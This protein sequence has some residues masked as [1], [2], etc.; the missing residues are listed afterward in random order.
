MFLQNLL[1]HVNILKGH[2]TTGEHIELEIKILL[3]PR[4]KTPAFFKLDN[5]IHSAITTIQKLVRN[6]NQ[7]GTA[8]ISQT[9]NFIKT[10]KTH[11]FVKQLFFNNGIQD[12]NKK[13]YYIKKSIVPPVYL[14]SETLNQPSYKLSVNTETEHNSD[15]NKF[16]IVRFR[17]RYSISFN[18]E[19]LK[20]W[21]LELTLVKE[22][23]NQSLEQM[24]Q[25][26]DKLFATNITKDTF[27]E[28]ADWNNVDRIELE[29]E[30]INSN[31]PISIEHIS[32][33]DQLWQI[34]NVNQR[35]YTDCICQIAQ[36]IKPNILDKFKSG[37][38]GLKQLGTNP[39]ELTKKDYITNVL[40]NINNFILTEKIDG[41]RSMLIIYPQKGECHIINKQYN[42]VVCDPLKFQSSFTN[43]KVINQLI[44]GEFV[45]YNNNSECK[46]ELIILDTEEY[47]V[48]NKTLYYV[49]D[50]IWY[51][52]NVSN[53]PFA[54]GSENRLE[55]IK[56]AVNQYDFLK[57]K[58]FI[59]LNDKDYSSQIQ[60]FN[61]MLPTLP[62][63][64][65]GLIF[66][67]KDT[68]YTKTV[69]MKW[70]PINKMT[71]DFVAKV[72]PP[73]LLG[74][75]PYI[76][77]DGQT[78]YLLFVGTRSDEYHKLGIKKFKNYEKIF[79]NVQYN[80][81]YFPI[82]FSPSSDPYAYLFW[83]ENSTLDGHIV[84]LTRINNSW[85][86]Y[87]IR[88]D[89]KIDMDRKT[90]YGNYFKYAESIWMNY[91]NPLTLE[92]LSSITQKN[93]GYFQEDDNLQYT[94]VRKFNNFVKSNLNQLYNK[95]YTTNTKNEGISWVIDLASGKGQDL[96]KYIEY[97]IHNILMIDIDNISL[98][99]V[100]NR[101]YKYIN[102]VHINNK[103]NI[104]IKQLDLSES[105][106]KN[107]SAIH[108]SRFGISTDGV[109]LIVCNF[110][111]H[112]LIPTK[113]KI[114]NFT[115]LLNKLLES[116]GIFIFTAFNGKK[117]FDLLE[118]SD[119]GTWERRVNDSKNN[120]KLLY[121]IKKKYI[122][123]DF[124][125]INQKIDVLLP[126]SN[127]N[128][129]TE[130]LINTELLVDE[131]AKKKIIL[132]AEDSF[133]IYLNKFKEFKPH[134]HKSLTNIDKEFISLYSF[135]IFHKQNKTRR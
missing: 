118:K 114:Q 133:D 92:N 78:L 2:H 44:S 59:H 123:T 116:G 87:K 113:K 45:N 50:V 28:K 75:N 43:D 127:G 12:K 89:R 48:E 130:Y 26:R 17:L 23:T 103:T 16:D 94:Y 104:F 108:E 111:L 79:K 31:K 33:L 96:L 119:T 64:N 126:F 77:K 49:F 122:G 76:N 88:Y 56:K 60:Q 25:I 24:K 22:T 68:N 46:D 125:G 63:E 27:L 62:Y 117:V 61:D 121:S 70:K 41:M 105:F 34:L 36:I 58:H 29:L 132:V 57:S 131:L 101:K 97:K 129:Y 71:I 4:I 65:D 106:T 83:S 20:D 93:M 91:Q 100:I 66:I 110:A 32:N 73:F 74:I 11:M 38:F 99:E 72:C 30:Y 95:K 47:I 102:N 7:Y 80:D 82:Q 1:N 55:Y 42:K 40:S 124:T 18:T 135:Y 8:D 39:V 107:V 5:N 21:K 112:Y 37:Y 109:P 54:I 90:Y 19:E 35:T 69:N 81:Q 9:I 15:I 52:K 53:L 115:G 134:F 13:Q 98:M 10:E 120:D 86:L 85:Q 14:I 84:E 6:A 3:D 67:S 128:Y 51:N